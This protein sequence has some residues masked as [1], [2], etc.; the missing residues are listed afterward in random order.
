[1]TQTDTDWEARCRLAREC[2]RLD[3]QLEQA[4]EELAVLRNQRIKPDAKHWLVESEWQGVPCTVECEIDEATGDG[5]DEP[6]YE[7]MASAMWVW[8]AGVRIDA[9]HF[10]V[11]SQDRWADEALET[12]KQGAE[13]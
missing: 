6:R 5:W 3:Y 7:A 4:R 8:I 2:G 11:A 12:I 1:M 10:P 13:A 9:G